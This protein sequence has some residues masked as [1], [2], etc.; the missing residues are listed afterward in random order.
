PRC[1]AH[2]ARLGQ[3]VDILLDT[4]L[5]YSPAGTPVTLSLLQQ[6]GRPVLAI[7]DSGPGIDPEDLPRIFEPFFRSP[8]RQASNPGGVGLGLAIARRIVTVMG[9]EVVAESQ[10]GHVSRFLVRLAATA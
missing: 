5:R 10:P 8:R 2:P 3:V 1:R 7:A 9:G 6:D 4:A